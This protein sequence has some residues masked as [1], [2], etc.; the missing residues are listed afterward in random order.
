MPKAFNA[1]LAFLQSA[2]ISNF[3]LSIFFSISLF[4]F[5]ANS[6]IT[7]GSGLKLQESY[8]R[9][10]QKY[11]VALMNN[12]EK[13]KSNETGLTLPNNKCAVAYHYG[14]DKENIEQL[15]RLYSSYGASNE[16]QQSIVADVKS[17]QREI[18]KLNMFTKAYADYVNSQRY[19]Q[20]EG[21]GNGQLMIGKVSEIMDGLKLDLRTLDLALDK[22]K[23]DT[24]E[25][26]LADHPLK[27]MLVPMV[28]DMAFLSQ[29]MVDSRNSGNHS[30][31]LD[32]ISSKRIELAMTK[33][34]RNREVE[35]L[36]KGSEKLKMYNNFYQKYNAILTQTEL[37]IKDGASDNGAIG[38]EGLKQLNLS[39]ENLKGLFTAS[40]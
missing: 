7:N 24:E 29:I 39:F 36:L 16:M 14:A 10:L 11:E 2:K 18:K 23:Y 12:F 19:L 3:F 20:D 25:V 13:V 6:L 27:I 9:A 1:P 40:N 28:Q 22:M 5:S 34:K 17:C 38:N 15:E 4:S 35:Y 33:E 37:R 21:K 8:A 30:Q 32:D 26:Y 31:T